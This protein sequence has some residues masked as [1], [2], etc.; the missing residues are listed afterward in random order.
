M[1]ERLRDLPPRQAA[2]WFSGVIFVFAGLNH[3]I[4]PRV[5][6]QIM[7]PYLPFPM[8]LIYLSGVTEVIG[9]TGLLIPRTRRAAGWLLMLTLIGVYPANVHMALYPEQF[10]PVPAWVLRARL[11]LQFVLIALVWWVMG[12][13]PTSEPKTK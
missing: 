1:I 7:P 11:P 10:K 2:R 9:G 4:V 13:A 8:M 12:G 3:F 5:Y 6:R